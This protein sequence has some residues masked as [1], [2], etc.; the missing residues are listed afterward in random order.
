[1]TTTVTGQLKYHQP[2]QGTAMAMGV[3]NI[4]RLWL[5]D[6]AT[7]VCGTRRRSTQ[8]NWQEPKRAT[9]G[10]THNV[11]EESINK[12]ITKK[13]GGGGGG[14][15][16]VRGQWL[17]DY[18]TSVLGDQTKCAGQVPGTKTR[19]IWHNPQRETERTTCK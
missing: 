19:S 11:R 3:P 1:M 8:G 4:C 15:G 7:S 17:L 6:Y 16:R 2:H 18:A 13:Q 14:G 12:N 10:T 5:L 9:C